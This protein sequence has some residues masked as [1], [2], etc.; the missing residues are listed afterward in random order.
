M[1]I[2][3]IGL[4]SIA[5]RHI[6]NLKEM[7]GAQARIYVMRT[8]L[9]VAPKKEVAAYIEKAVYQMEELDDWYDIV[10]ITNPTSFHLETLHTFRDRSDS[11]FI[12]KPVF[13]TGWEDYSPFLLPG[14]QYYVACPLR[15]TKVVQYLKGNVDFSL[16]HSVRC[17]SSSYLPDWRPGTDYRKTYSANRALGGGVAIDLVHEWDYLC[18][19]LGMPLRVKSIQAKKSGLETD[20]DDIAVYIAEYA[21]MVVELHLDYFGRNPVRRMELLTEEDTIEADLLNGK[22]VWHVCGKEEELGQARDDFHKRE[23]AHFLDIIGGRARNDND[24]ERACR[25]LRLAHSGLTEEG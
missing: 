17:I 20:V 8:G 2:L 9:G 16:V 5:G 4:G 15:Y 13:L 6:R 3:F 12:E 7:L 22:V 18:Y 23:L 10:F 14:K 1:K 25:I 19:L 24:L 11:F 21:N